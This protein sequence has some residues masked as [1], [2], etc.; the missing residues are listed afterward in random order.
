MIHLTPIDDFVGVKIN[1][2]MMVIII[3]L[4]MRLFFI[5]FA[6]RR[7]YRATSKTC[8]CNCRP[9]KLNFVPAR[10]VSISEVAKLE[11][12]ASLFAHR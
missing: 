8:R 11:S 5:Y 9:S 3:S 1:R 12:A 6:S 4:T 2:L 10:L 7:L